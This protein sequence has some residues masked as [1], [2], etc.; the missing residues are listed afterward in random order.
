MH[1]TDLPCSICGSELTDQAISASQTPVETTY[2]GR[3]RIAACPNCRSRY[4]PDATLETL[5][6]RP[7]DGD[8]YPDT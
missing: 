7:T 8:Q 5:S 1:E 6:G 2:S 4:Y 3:I